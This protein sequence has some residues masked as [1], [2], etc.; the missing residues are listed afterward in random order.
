MLCWLSAVQMWWVLCVT[1]EVHAR[2]YSNWLESHSDRCD[3][4]SHCRHCRLSHH[5]CH[6][7]RHFFRVTEHCL[8]CHPL[9]STVLLLPT[10][11]YHHDH[12]TKRKSGCTFFWCVLN[13]YFSQRVWTATKMK[14]ERSINIVYDFQHFSG[15]IIPVGGHLGKVWNTLIVAERS[16]SATTSFGNVE[17][18]LPHKI[19]GSVS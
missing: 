11:H 19:L 6:H 9:S 1:F 2:S 12:H 5:H 17:R 8:C 7:S 4:S 14:K 10:H 13:I 18:Y 3:C 15:N 16:L